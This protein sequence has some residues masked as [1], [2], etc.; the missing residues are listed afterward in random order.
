MG[1]DSLIWGQ[2]TK[3]TFTI[4]ESYDLKA[5]Q[6]QDGQAL[7]WKKIWKGGWWPKVTHF[8]WLVCKGRIITW[9]QL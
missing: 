6:E 3:G 7:L 4:K 2:S 9:D 8:L 1:S 5:E